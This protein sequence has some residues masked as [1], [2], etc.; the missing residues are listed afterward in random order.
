[1]LRSVARGTLKNV[2]FR[3]VM[4]LESLRWKPLLFLIKIQMAILIIYT[5]QIFYYTKNTFRPY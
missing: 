3:Q 2:T 4:L 1:M 5:L